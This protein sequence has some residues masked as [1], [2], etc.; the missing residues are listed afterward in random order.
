MGFPNVSLR[1][2]QLQQLQEVLD[3]LRSTGYRDTVDVLVHLGQFLTVKSPAGSVR[4]RESV[5]DCRRVLCAEYPDSAEERRDIAAVRAA[6]DS[7]AR[8]VTGVPIKV[9]EM[10][11]AF[12][13]TVPYPRRDSGPAA[14][15]DAARRNHRLIIMLSSGQR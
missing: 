6:V 12:P 3:Q 10:A 14:W 15:N 1:P 11:A 7:V 8:K 5:D 4:L 2:E 13:A 9:G